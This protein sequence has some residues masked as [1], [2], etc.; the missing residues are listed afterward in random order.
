MS[1]YAIKLTTLGQHEEKKNIPAFGAV[2]ADQLLT[3]NDLE[4][5]AIRCTNGYLWVTL[6]GDVMDHVLREDQLFTV[7]AT[8]KVIIG[9]KGGFT[10]E[11]AVKMPMAS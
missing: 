2:K 11:P 5:K 1:D 7:P 4:G 3:V 6:Q 8:G 10:I 9:G